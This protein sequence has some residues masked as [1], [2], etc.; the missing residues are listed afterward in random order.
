MQYVILV[1]AIL[2]GVNESYAILK[3]VSE[4]IK[5]AQAEGSGDLSKEDWNDLWEKLDAANAR[6]DAA[7]ADLRTRNEN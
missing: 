7:M 5:R 4:A 6:R 3:E 2:E 1:L